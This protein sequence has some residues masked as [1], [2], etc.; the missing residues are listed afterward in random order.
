MNRALKQGP[1]ENSPPS[2]ADFPSS[3]GCELRHVS[4]GQGAECRVQISDCTREALACRFQRLHVCPRAPVIHQPGVPGSAVARLASPTPPLLHPIDHLAHSIG[5]GRRG[6]RSSTGPVTPRAR[7]LAL[8]G[9]ERLIQRQWSPREPDSR[10]VLFLSAPGSDG[11]ARALGGVRSD[12]A[13][14]RYR[15][16]GEAGTVR[17]PHRMGPGLAGLVFGSWPIARASL[18]RINAVHWPNSP[19]AGAWAGT[20]HNAGAPDGDQRQTR[21]PPAF[22]LF[23]DDRCSRPSGQVAAR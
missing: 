15:P 2:P 6:P 4:V 16:G 20:S 17:G 11:G 8:P 23:G 5:A 18:S 1:S 3:P 21:V 7:L 9:A 13:A 10:W 19:A 22:G 12:A 14:S